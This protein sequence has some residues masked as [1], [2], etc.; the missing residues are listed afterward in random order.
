[1]PPSLILKLPPAIYAISVSI[2]VP[3]P[4]SSVIFAVPD[5]SLIFTVKVCWVAS[6]QSSSIAATSNV[7]VDAFAGSVI[8][9]GPL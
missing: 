5:G 1:M 3:S 8:V 2:T 6:T 7:T 4:I 9:V